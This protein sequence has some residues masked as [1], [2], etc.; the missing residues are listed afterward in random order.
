MATIYKSGKGYRAI[1]RRKGDKPLSKNFTAKIDAVKWARS[2]EVE[3]DQKKRLP[4]GLSTTVGE[5]VR[6]YRDSLKKKYGTT[7]EWNMRLI[8]QELGGLKLDEM[9]RQRVTQFVASRERAGAGPSTN[10][11]TLGY[12]KTCIKYGGGL[13]DADDGLQLA[14]A[15]LDVLWTTM[16]H[17]GR[18]S[19]SKERNRRP[20]EEELEKLFDH[21]DTRPRSNTPMTDIVCFA[22]ATCMRLG[23]IIGHKS[24]IRWED[25]NEQSR[26]ILIRQRKDPTTFEGRDMEVPLLCGHV[27]LLNKKIDPVEIMLRQKTARRREGRVFPYS[28]PTVG[29]G[30]SRACDALGIDDLRFHD[31][32]HDGISRMFEHG[33]NIPQVAAVSGHKS[34]KNLQRY[35]HI[36]PTSLHTAL[37]NSA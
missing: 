7:K 21:F 1:V 33:Y 31:L 23:E 25:F 4:A 17:T 36:S 37:P 16:M 22:I 12:V 35:T 19:H 5:C 28:N 13:L 27:V 34:W 29:F 15:N 8:E 6:A 32:R 24:G 3:A 26:T 30:F 14:L 18:I 11:Q 20:S 2:I 10:G 9:T